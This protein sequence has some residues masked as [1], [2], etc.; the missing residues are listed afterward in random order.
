VYFNPLSQKLTNELANE[1]LNLYIATKNSNTESVTLGDTNIENDFRN[2]LTIEQHSHS[3]QVNSDSSLMHAMDEEDSQAFRQAMELSNELFDDEC[4]VNDI[5]ASLVATNV[6]CNRCKLNMEKKAIAEKNPL[7]RTTVHYKQNVKH[8][9]VSLIEAELFNFNINEV[10]TEHEDSV[11]S[12]TTASL[13]AE[14]DEIVESLSPTL[15]SIRSRMRI[16][17]Y[18]RRIIC[19]SLCIQLFPIGFLFIIFSL[20]YC[21][22]T[23]V[24]IITIIIIIL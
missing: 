19:T 15:E 20:L 23:I 12:C 14:I 11:M 3:L 21:I 9:E 24:I 16:F 1:Q 18:V 22:I 17:Q 8:T 13:F 2:N 6:A 7:S 5:C 10:K 4:D